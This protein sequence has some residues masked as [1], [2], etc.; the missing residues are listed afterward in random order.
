M[1]SASDVFVV[2]AKVSG[3]EALRIVEHALGMVVERY[4]FGFRGYGGVVALVF[5]GEEFIQER[6]LA[7]DIASVQSL[8]RGG[9][10]Q[11]AHR[12][13]W[14][15]IGGSL[16]FP[17]EQRQY[18][19]DI[20][21]YPTFD[22]ERPACVVFRMDPSLYTEVDGSDGNGFDEDAAERLL[23]LCISLGAADE[24]D[25]FQAL[26]LGELEEVHP[27]DGPELRAALVSPR[28]IR[29]RLSGKKVLQH[30]FVTG[31]RKTILGGVDLTP[32]WNGYRVLETTHGFVILSRLVDL[33]RRPEKP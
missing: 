19:F 16:R 5:E 10:E 30:G 2:L 9:L 32:S 27:F 15:S 7:E 20:I 11:L 25:G 26:L 18:D 3:E 6:K 4:D 23:K 33:R 8:D 12:E 29:D 14:F 28:S 31:I 13:H 21:M 17:N 22:A 24:V 1:A